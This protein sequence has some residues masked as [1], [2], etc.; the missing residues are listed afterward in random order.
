MAG[1]ND[2]LDKANKL[3]KQIEAI[4]KRLGE[5]NPFNGMDPEKIST[6]EKEIKKLEVALVGITNKAYDLEAGFGGITAAIGASLAEMNET[7]NAVNRTVKSMRGIKNITQDLANDQ[8]GLVQLSLKELQNRESKLKTLSQEARTQSLL[9]KDQYE[10]FNLDKN[11]D[12]L[13]GAALDNRLKKLGISKSEAQKIEEILAAEEEGLT[14]L[15]DAL[16]KTK[17]RIKYEESINKKLGITGGLL[18][19]ISKIPIL[20][21]VFDANEAV[22]EMDEHLRAGG[23][24]VGALGKGFKNMAKQAKDSL[25]NSANLVLGAFTMILSIFKDL[26]SGAGDFA[27]SMNMTY[28]ESLG[29]RDEMSD[30]A[31]SSG[32]ASVNSSRM[33]E[34]LS[35]VGNQL[36]S[37]AQLS[38][39]NALQFTRMREEAGMTNE[40]L[41]GITNLSLAGGKS[42]KENTKQFMAQ[43]K[44][45][46]LNNGVLLNEK[47]LLADIDKLSKATTLS[48]GKNPKEIAKAVATAKSLG[49][50]MS[51]IEGMAN[52]LL[53]FE[54]SI[55]N[56][57]SAELLLGKDINLEKARTAALNND[58]A[59]LAR[60]IS[61][62]IGSAAEFTK[63]NRIQQE[64]LAQAV[65]MNR[66]DLAQTLFTQEALKGLSGEELEDKQRMLDARIEQVGL[67]QAQREL[68]DGS[69]ETMEEQQSIQEQFAD[70]MLAL[71]E[72]LVNGIL[73]AFI[74]IGGFL[75]EHMG[76]VKVLIGLYVAMKVAQIGFNAAQ[77]ISIAL[78]KRKKALSMAEAVANVVKGGWSSVGIIPII[79]AALAVLAIGGGIAYLYSQSS[80]AESKVNDGMFP[81]AGGSGYGKRVLT[82]PEGS[83]Q[84]NNKDTVIAGTNLFGDD[85]KSSP[86]K[87]TEMGGKDEIKV[88]SDGGGKVD[89]TQTNALLQQLINVI[90][91]SGNVMLDGQ[92]VGT[93]LKLGSFKTQ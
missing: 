2:N 9:V 5:T 56:E 25:F 47:K 85:I 55:E 83:I 27:K 34:T 3:L 45:T 93:A 74:S 12:K 40:E 67:A 21:D 92:K 32:I 7:D 22:S 90:Q 15:D 88:K 84:L 77:Q 65:G 20:G 48:L 49:M 38:N 60:E 70:Q 75:S 53:D 91:T 79:G 54:S 18:K 51:N 8:A 59:G 69:L 6:S 57:L 62:E 44:I 11:G 64:A 89:M 86:N 80:K 14:V 35:A 61:K 16:D 72:T 78:G 1:L 41:M 30:I 46:G 4:Y 71:K 52:S 10:G 50:E 31:L 66:E 58:I 37:N 81:A 24:S 28:T 39:E 33:M 76:I 43:A 19:G 26:D 42:I 36:G 68:E 29:V 17:E 87:P 73:P 13:M 82:G 23:S 63:M